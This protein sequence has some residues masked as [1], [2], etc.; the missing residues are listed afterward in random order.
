MVEPQRVAALTV[1]VALQ[2]AEDRHV[3]ALEEAHKGVFFAA[4]QGLAHAQDQRSG[5]RH[6]HRVEDEDRVGELRQ[7]LVVVEELD[8]F[9]LEDG[10]EGVVGGLRFRQVD[11]SGVVP[12]GRVRGG[13][14]FVGPPHDYLAQPADHVLGAV[15]LAH[16]GAS[17]EIAAPVIGAALGPD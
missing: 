17:R 8:A 10:H 13:H 12:R 4:A 3:L 15:F 16:A 6:Q 5:V 14:R 2:A 9:I 1:G 7:R 11:G